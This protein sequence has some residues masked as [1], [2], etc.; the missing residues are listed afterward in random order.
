MQATTRHSTLERFVT[1]HD[2]S[3]AEC[4][5]KPM[6]ALA[7][8]ESQSRLLR[9]ASRVSRIVFRSMLIAATLAPAFTL[10]QDAPPASTPP[11]PVLAPGPAPDPAAVLTRPLA[12][13]ALDMNIPGAAA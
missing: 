11:A 9:K 8:A 13:V 4:A 10:A 3:R 7:P 6:L 2:F 12:I 1:G 5:A